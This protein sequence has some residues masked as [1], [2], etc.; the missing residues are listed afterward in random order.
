MA[1]KIID[2][3]R[4]KL[5]EAFAPEMLDV[6]DDSARHAGHA[7]HREGGETHFKVRIVS[8]AFEGT[9]RIERQRKVYATLAEEL[10]ERVHALQIDA[11]TPSEV[12]DTKPMR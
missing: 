12:T 5:T 1:L 11:K 7:G 2:R 4:A 3:I 8:A 6:A 10:K 9:S